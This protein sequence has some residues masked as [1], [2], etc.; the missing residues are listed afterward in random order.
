MG[1]PSVRRRPD[2]GEART[3]LLDAAVRIIRRQ[4]LHATSVDQL[5]AEAGVTKGAFF[6]HFASKEELAVAAAEHWSV[7]TGALFAAAPYHDHADPA[8]RVL[9]YLD[10]RASRIA[11]R[12][13][14]YTCLVGTM[15]QEAFE[16]SVAVR[17]ACA[18][19]IFGHADT[20]EDDLAAALDAVDHDAD[21]TASSLARH[22][23]TVLQ[24]AFVLS[25]AA[26]DPALVLEAIGHLRR[27]LACVLGRET[28]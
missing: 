5:C 28:C 2:R 18:D 7:T 27:Y 25:K 12:P 22:T 13:A 8:D 19:S 9:G 21:I 6:H 26:D 10:F 20:L 4:G 3:A 24:G 17:D 15:T 23:Q 16:T 14:E 1:E 11:G